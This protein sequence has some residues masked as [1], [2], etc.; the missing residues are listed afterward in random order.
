MPDDAAHILH[1]PVK[2]D[3]CEYIRNGYNPEIDTVAIDLHRVAVSDRDLLADY[4]VQA[5][6]DAWHCVSVVAGTPEA[7]LDAVRAKARAAKE[8]AED[9]QV[10][11]QVLQRARAVV[12][13]Q[14]T[15]VERELLK[16]GQREDEVV[17]YDA[18][19]PDW[20]PG[21]TGLDGTWVYRPGHVSVKDVIRE[22]NSA[23][24]V[25]ELDALNEQRRIA[26]KSDFEQQRAAEKIQFEDGKKILRSWAQSRPDTC[27]I[28]EAQQGNWVRKLENLW[29]E[30][31]VPTGYGPLSPAMRVI[32]NH[33]PS[34][35]DLDALKDAQSACDGI[36]VSDARLGLARAANARPEKTRNM[37]GIAVTAPTGYNR[38]FWRRITS[39]V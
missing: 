33:D 18:V 39:E 24:W 3:P 20:P 16:V 30:D 15:R 7:V 6:G 26:A 21:V 4:Y 9:A 36:V 32:E 22:T 38:M 10:R 1:V 11:A 31:R 28:V 5:T 35:A 14:R 27:K 12:V 2:P 19:V 25:A 13:E 8:R 34:P 37:V 23:A 29:I 17:S